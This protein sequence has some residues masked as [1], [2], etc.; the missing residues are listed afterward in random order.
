MDLRHFHRPGCTACPDQARR[1]SR[2][3][4]W[5]KNRSSSARSIPSF[6]EE[7]GI[8]MEDSLKG[9]GEFKHFNDFFYRRL[10]P[11]ARPLAGGEDTAVFPR[12]PGTW[13]GNALT[14][15]RAFS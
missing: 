5:L 13:A 3:L 12:M 4:G 15:S 10:K 7:Y 8:N 6:V 1:F 2:L 14:E 9:M 11:G